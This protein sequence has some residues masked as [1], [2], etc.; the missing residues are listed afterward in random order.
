MFEAGAMGLAA[1]AAG[2]AAAAAPAP[3][4]PAG[5]AAGM[6]VPDQASIRPGVT[7][8]P[9]PSITRASFGITAAE[10]T[11][12]TSPSRRT[13]VAFSATA[14]ETVTTFTLVMAYEGVLAA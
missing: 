3:P 2:A 11:S 13:R 9:L 6:P 1:G 10:P 12:I 7:V 8:R 4:P 5:R 14:P